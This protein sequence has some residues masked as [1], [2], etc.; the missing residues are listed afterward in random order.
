MTAQE[1]RRMYID[2]FIAR[3]HKEISTSSLIPENDPSV[4][5]TTAGMH[6]L[7]PYLLGEK[8]PLG[9]RL[10]DVQKCLRTGDIDQVG[11]ANHLTFFEMM[12]N[13]SLGDYFKKESIPMSHEFLT[14]VLGIP[15]ERIFVTVFA[16][17]ASAPRDDESAEIW[18]GLGY[19]D[20]QMFY[21]GKKE[22]W[23]GPAGLTGPCG[24]DTEIFFDT[25][26]AKCSERCEPAC[27]CGK[28]VEIWNNVFM[29]YTKDIDGNYVKMP[30]K[31]VDTGLGLERVLAIMNQVSSV[32][33]TALFTP[34][35]QRIEALT[36]VK[37]EENAFRPFRIVADHLRA[38][39]FVLGDDKGVAPS[40]V[41]QGYIL[42]RLIRRAYRYL[43]QMNASAGAMGRIAEV[44]M[45]QYHEVYPELSR[46]RGFVVKQLDQEEEVF[47]R[48]LEQ[49]LK[50]ATKY[51]AKTA[52]SKIL[53]G[54][55]VFRLYDTFGFP[56]EFTQEL[57]E[58]KGIAVDTEGFHRLF[59]EHQEK[60]RAGAAQKFRGGLADNSAET[61]KLHTATHLLNAAL[62][63]VLGDTVYQRGSN[64][65]PE[66]LRFDFSFDRKVTPEELKEVEHIVNQAITDGVDVAYEEMS[67][68]E[69]KARGAIG[70]FTDKYGER[71]K[72]YSIG[73]YS[74]EICGGPHVMNTREL[75]SF[76]ILQEGSSS[77]GVRRI[78]AVI[79]SGA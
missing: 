3:D 41:D 59:A 68:D 69:A 28:Y 10:V 25:G 67:V 42:R 58:E 29:E 23:W 24:P 75:V 32:F 63:R 78:K 46:N 50:M 34:I 13:W 51:L 30:V 47:S 4:L 73:T 2:F 64:I 19:Q 7:V 1:L 48:A 21:Y 45:D 26:K 43:T 17:D 65:N 5:F 72:V 15:R 35:I 52:D 38:A 77:A 14:K 20:H 53:E 6:P 16:G 79:G 76:K 36:G 70:V 54:K 40:N 71:V 39:V 49:G 33:D 9:K 60:S 56:L 12:G 11:D 62:R 31:N 44:V 8:H 27:G 66:R 57:A 18:K 74:K 55:D 61:T 37:Y 22:N